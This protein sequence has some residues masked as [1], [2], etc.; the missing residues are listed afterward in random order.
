MTRFGHELPVATDRY[1]EGYLRRGA[2]QR[3]FQ[4]VAQP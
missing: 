1:R 3:A 4:G 2:D